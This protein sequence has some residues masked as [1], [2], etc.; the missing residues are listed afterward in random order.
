MGKRLVIGL[1]NPGP[2]F[3]QTWHNLGFRIT[4]EIALK[5]KCS[6]KSRKEALIGRS[7]SGKNEIILMLPQTYMNLSG[8]PSARWAKKLNIAEEDILVILDDHDL[9]RGSLR[10]RK[11]GGDGG[12][13]GL[14]SVLNELNSNNIPRLRVG[15]R[16]E[17][18]SPDVGGYDDLADKVLDTLSAREEMHLQK[19]KVVAAN[20]VRE[21]LNNGISSA[22]NK[23][24]N[25]RII[26]PIGNSD[27]GDKPE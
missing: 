7:G 3:E 20:A 21:W 13:R 15:I 25:R 8:L 16:D 4:R 27:P 24:N 10:I 22:M 18:E 17:R 26:L 2:K 9:P 11:A 19:I 12:H 14:R 1:G 23:Y 5:I 6:L